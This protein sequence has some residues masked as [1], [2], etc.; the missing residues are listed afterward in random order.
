MSATTPVFTASGLASGMDTSSIINQLVQLESQPI[1][2]L[3]TTQSNIKT[4]VSALGAISS[5]LSALDSAAQDLGTNGAFASSAVSANA[6]FTATP[7]SGATP[8]SYSVEVD[9][10]ASAAKWRSSG[11]G[12][13]A[14]VAGGTLQLTVQGVTYDPI[15]IQDGAS[16]GD[17]ADAIRQTGAPVSAMVVNDGTNSYLTLTDRDTGYPIGGQP[18]DA[19]SLSFT[20]D[21]A[22]TGQDPGFAQLQPPASNARFQVDGLTFTRTSNTVSDALPGVTLTLK[23]AT[24]VPEDLELA[25]DTNGTQARLQ[26]FV[27]AYNSVM[28]LL[29]ANLS[30]AKDTNRAVTLTGDSNVRAL[31]ASLQSFLSSEVPGL[32]GVR[33]LADIGIKTGQDGMLSIDTTTLSNALSADPNAHDPSSDVDPTTSA[34]RPTPGTGPPTAR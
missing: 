16:L 12:A 23:S 18:S 26:T 3:Q 34:R 5:A 11:F 8:G 4:Q 10:L 24:K 31:E 9:S 21:P 1:T 22:A 30:P 19:L 29:Q 33:T 6:S 32:G 27:S 28:Q 7:G 25:A 13:N 14:T 17:V 2:D 20:A 15:T